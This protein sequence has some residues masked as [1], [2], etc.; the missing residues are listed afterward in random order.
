[1]IASNAS[2]SKPGE[3]YRL[4][5]Y[6]V[7]LTVIGAGILLGL[8]WKRL[9]KPEWQGRTIL[10]SIFLPVGMLALALGW[11][12]LLIPHSELPIQFIMSMPML[13]LGANFGFIW[14]LARLQN[15]AYKLFKQKG[16]EA[17]DRYEYDVDG[18]M[19]FGGLVT[20][21]WAVIGVFLI[22]LL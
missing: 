5:S 2:P 17:L 6:F 3:P 19:F 22:P 11:V 1:M 12:F 7:F 10:L 4:M 18:A 16:V 20:L 9:G 13:A 8:N 14:A 21:A 15:G